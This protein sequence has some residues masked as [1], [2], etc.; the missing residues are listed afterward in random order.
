MIGQVRDW[1]ST[2]PL[3]VR[4]AS[5]RL[6]VRDVSSGRVFDDEPVLAVKRE[7]PHR[8]E[9]VGGRQSRRAVGS[10]PGLELV[11]PFD[12]PRSLLDDFVPAERLLQYAFRDVLGKGMMQPA[13]L[14]VMHPLEKLDGG[15]TAVERRAFQELALGAGARKVVVVTGAELSDEAVR[16]QLNSR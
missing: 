16:K 13:P 14:V 3:Y 10:Q 5:D 6:T 8:I 12:H 15:L 7:A 2:G 11:N 9:A 4:I 1:L